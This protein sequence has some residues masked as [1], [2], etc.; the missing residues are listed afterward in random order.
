MNARIFLNGLVLVCVT[1]ILAACKNDSPTT[2]PENDAP[3]GA[4]D[5]AIKNGEVTIAGTLDLPSTPGPYP[6]MIF[7]P[8][9]G[10]ETREADRPVRDILL[11]RGVAL[12]RYDKR[13]L[14]QS[15]GA[16]QNVNLQNSTQLIPERASDVLAIVNF[17]ATHQDINPKQIF[18]WGTSQGAWVAPLVANQTDKVAFIICV[19]GGGSSVGV[20]IY[21]D[22]LAD[23]ASLSIEQ[24]TAMLAN[25]TGAHGYD[26]TAALQALNV[27]ALWVYGGMDRSNPTF[28]DITQLEKIK[29]ERNKDFTV[30]LFPNMNHDLIDVTTSQFD[31]QF[32]PQIFA[33]GQS[34]LGR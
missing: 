30:L 27:P 32:F 34:K 10:Q 18:L 33:W 19:N 31:P 6:V 2:P 11:P 12:F 17:L 14:G 22:D 29:Q 16:Y 28:Y 26:P 4:G 5:F 3:K 7:I 23:N 8:G 24:L 21:Y 13:G 9:S 20:E 25:Y 1:L 15:T